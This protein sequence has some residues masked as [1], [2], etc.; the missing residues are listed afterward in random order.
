MGSSLCSAPEAAVCDDLGRAVD[1][2]VPQQAFIDVARGSMHEYG[3]PQ[4][5][6]VAQE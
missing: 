3:R 6:V 5:Y 2:C 1:S 4:L